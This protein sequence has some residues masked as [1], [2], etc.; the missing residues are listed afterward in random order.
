MFEEI[1]ETLSDQ[2]PGVPAGPYFLPWTATDAR[3]FRTQ[4]VPVYG[5]S[6][7]LIMNTDTL[8]RWTG[9]TSG[10][11]SPASWTAWSSTPSWCGVWSLTLSANG[12]CQILS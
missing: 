6:P 7:F 12:L 9:P 10:S 1:E 11:P 8:A 2:Y 4:G 5:F 3:F